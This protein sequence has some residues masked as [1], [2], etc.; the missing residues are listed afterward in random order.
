MRVLLLI[1]F[2]PISIC[3]ISQS[4][5]ELFL[6][7]NQKY[8]AGQYQEALSEYKQV[9]NKGKHSSELYHNIGNSY[10]K[11]NQLGYAILYYEKAK[12]LQP[13]NKLINNNLTIAR[14]D[15]DSDIVEIPD[16][17]PLRLWRSISKSLSPTMW[18]ILQLLIGIGMVISFYKYWFP[19]GKLSGLQSLSLSILLGALL[20]LSF[21]AGRTSHKLLH[22][23]N[24]GI[25][26]NS[27][28]LK[29]APDNRSDNIEP[30]SEGV[31]VDIT[32][33]I[34]QWYKVQLMNKN[35]GWI[36]K[37]DVDRI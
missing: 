34:D 21:L 8:T 22:N 9:E 36:S 19:Y 33:N 5:E 37:N 32:D 15:V 4:S 24:S 14:N 11:L 26:I 27:A 6:S 10:Y 31:K 35:I 23:H 17:L 28:M 13:N 25:V 20:I 30:L 7:A 18:I 3:S 16:F 12:L 29:S 1:I 2:L